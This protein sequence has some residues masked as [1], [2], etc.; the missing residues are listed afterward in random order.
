MTVS[1]CC[2]WM[3]WLLPSTMLHPK[4]TEC[5][6]LHHF[7]IIFQTISGAFSISIFP[8]FLS[9]FW[10]KISCHGEVW[11]NDHICSGSWLLM[12]VSV[13]ASPPP[14]LNMGVPRDGA[15]QRKRTCPEEAALRTVALGP[16]AQRFGAYRH[17]KGERCRL[18]S[19]PW[20][21]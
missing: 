6:S 3:G 10:V 5:Q 9:N 1:L 8:L 12:L 14:S 18:G 21:F 16:G 2:F 19:V 11:L 20:Q 7:E 13:V 17:Q 15:S 4:K